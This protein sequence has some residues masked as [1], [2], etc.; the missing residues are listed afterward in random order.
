MDFRSSPSPATR[1]PQLRSR[2]GRRKGGRRGVLRSRLD[3]IAQGSELCLADA[4]DLEQIFDLFKR[5]M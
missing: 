5:P 4:R 1:V 3:Q 2:A